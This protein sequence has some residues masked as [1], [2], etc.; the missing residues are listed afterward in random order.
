MNIKRSLLVG[1]TVATVSLGGLA[2]VGIASAATDTSSGTTLAERIA[3]KFNL[4]Q[5][6]VQAVIDEDREARQAER[7]AEQKEKLAEAVTN[8]K[9]TQEQADHITSVLDEIKILRGDTG[10]KDLSDEI[11]DQIKEKMDTLRDWADDNNIDKQYVMGMR[12]GH[13]GMRGGN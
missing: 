13:G 10:M 9:L 7:E 5:D 8:G 6:D 3:S 4:S 11:K 1:A 2:G 12:G